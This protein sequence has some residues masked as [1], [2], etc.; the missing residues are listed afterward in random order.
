MPW[1]RAVP[2]TAAGRRRWG[3]WYRTA[4]VAPTANGE[5]G[6][7]ANPPALANACPAALRLRKVR[8][9]MVM[10]SLLCVQRCVGRGRTRPVPGLGKLAREIYWERAQSAPRTLHLDGSA[11]L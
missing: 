2:C 4:Q 11:Y 9:C 3:R 7:P 8:R 1:V 6:A 5:L 10:G